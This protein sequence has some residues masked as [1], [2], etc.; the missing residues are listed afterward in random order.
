[1]TLNLI[2]MASQYDLELWVVLTDPAEARHYINTF[3]WRQPFIPQRIEVDSGR[4][5]DLEGLSDEDA[6]VVA[7]FLLREYQIPRE[8]AE[9]NLAMYEH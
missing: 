8:M 4:M 9:K 6:V 5:I 7:S 2:R 1:M 3:D